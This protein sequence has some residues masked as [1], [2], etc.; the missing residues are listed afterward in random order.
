MAN[1][2]FVALE[3]VRQGHHITQNIETV[4]QMSTVILNLFKVIYFQQ[5]VK[6]VSVE[7]QIL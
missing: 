7:R 5:F 3:L 2:D 1:F 4:L 6:K